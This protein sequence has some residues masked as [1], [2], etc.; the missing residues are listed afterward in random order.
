MPR[1]LPQSFYGRECLEVALELLGK[2]VRHGPVAL[3]ITEVEAYRHGVDTA[4]HCRFGV[5]KRNAPMWGAPGHAYVYLCY[6]LHQMLNLVTDEAGRGAAVLVRSCEVV[7]GLDEVRRRRGDKSGPVLL[8]GPGK[9]ASALGVD[10]S[11]SGQPLFRRGGLSVYDAPP[12]ASLL[13]GPRV[14]VD[15]AHPEHA[16]APWRLALAD[17]PWVS[18]RRTLR[19]LDETASSFLARHAL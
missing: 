19:E 16:S 7:A 9:V 4:N 6:G 17:T 3:R 14:G 5:T 2:I 11:Y 18:Q 12:P 10:T 1:I 8:T 13:V 15:Y